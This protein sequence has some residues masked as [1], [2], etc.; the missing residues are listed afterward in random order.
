MIKILIIANRMMLPLSKTTGEF[1][2]LIFLN[3]TFMQIDANIA[4][5]LLFRYSF[6]TQKTY[7]ECS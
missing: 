7:Y 6:H 1:F 4:M 5:A 3:L 2:T